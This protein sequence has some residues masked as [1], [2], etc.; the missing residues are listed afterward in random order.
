VTL[1]SNDPV[2]G[3]RLT[4]RRITRDDFELIGRWLAEPMVWRWW[5]DDPAPE[6]VQA[7]FGPTVDGADPTQ[8][9]VVALGGGPV[10]LIQRY[11][12][13]DEPEFGAELA[14][15]C[16]VPAGA[17]G[18]DYFVSEPANRGQGLG[19]RMIAALV[20]DC[21]SAYPGAP[22]VIVAVIVANRPSWRALER[23]GFRRV[24]QGPMT[25]DN[26]IDPPDHV[27]YRIDRPMPVH[28]A[29]RATIAPVVR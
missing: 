2:D 20:E 28:A 9:F 18:L 22:A 19:T 5:H 1:G 12:L 3:P 15:L 11:C 6:A 4:F 16:E 23:A 10:G 25:P 29:R 8:V 14:A 13:D 7:Q 27:I 17:L 21:W 26:P 24:A